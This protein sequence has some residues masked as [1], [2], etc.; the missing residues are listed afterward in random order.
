MTSAAGQNNQQKPSLFGQPAQP[1]TNAF[2]GFGAANQQQ[3][4]QQQQQPAGG[5]FGTA[6]GST[7][8]LFGSTQQNQPAGQQQP[9]TG[10]CE[11][12]PNIARAS[13]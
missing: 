4:Q 11:H 9:A 13:Y 7:G 12:F 8:G 2:G 5:L 1:T 10:G 6:G 3:G